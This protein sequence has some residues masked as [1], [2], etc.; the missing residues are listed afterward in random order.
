[1]LLFTHKVGRHSIDGEACVPQAKSNHPTRHQMSLQG[2]YLPKYTYFGANMAFWGLKLPLLGQ[3]SYFFSRGTKSVG[4]H[5]SENHW[6]HW[7]QKCTILTQKC[8]YWGTKVIFVL[9][10][11]FLSGGI[12]PHQY[13]RGYNFPVGPTLKKNL[14]P[15]YSSF[16]GAQLRTICW[17]HPDISFCFRVR[18]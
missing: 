13:T 11:Q 8:W 15:G 2:L 5:I 17:I 18:A 7:G 16:S 1:M 12:S 4:T 6:G 14:F 3:T 9:E 10:S